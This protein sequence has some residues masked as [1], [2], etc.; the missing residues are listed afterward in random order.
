M[1]NIRN[2]TSLLYKFPGPF[3]QIYEY[4]YEE[5]RD[6]QDQE[7]LDVNGGVMSCY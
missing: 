5:F 6:H 7:G 1:V 3:Y 4:G 2:K